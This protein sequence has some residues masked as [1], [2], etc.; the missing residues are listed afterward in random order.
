MKIILALV[1][2]V[3]AI[4]MAEGQAELPS[5][6]PN[7]CSLGDC[8]ENFAAIAK[9]YNAL[10]SLRLPEVR[11]VY[12][13]ECEFKGPH[14]SLGRGANIAIVVEKISGKYFVN[15]RISN[16]FDYDNKRK[17][18]PS[19][20]GKTPLQIR[21]SVLEFMSR[22]ENELRIGAGFGYRPYDQASGVDHLWIRTT[23]DGTQAIVLGY[24][25]WPAF[26]CD[27]KSTLID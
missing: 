1:L 15:Y 24:F 6:I 21:D 17:L 20:A 12:Q 2:S 5:G 18:V 7:L 13:G 26:A 23:V 4:A 3:S 10:E 8:T 27:L 25:G 16:L 19:W 9:A 14:S 22:P 11:S